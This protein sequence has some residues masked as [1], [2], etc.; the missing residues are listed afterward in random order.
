MSYQ[1]VDSD[2][3]VYMTHSIGGGLSLLLQEASLSAAHDASDRDPPPSCAPRTRE[4][5]IADIMNWI[6][7]SSPRMS[8]MWLNGPFGNGKSAIMQTIADRLRSDTSLEHH[9]AA[10]FFFGRGKLGRDKAKFLIPTIAYQITISIPST[11]QVIDKALIQDP[12]IILKKS[13]DA[14]LRYL[15]TR[16]LHEVTRHS[17]PSAPFHTPTVIIDGLDECEGHDFQ[18]L[19]LKAIS[20]AV[21]K[22]HVPL[23]FLI[24]SRPDAQ[25]SETFRIQPLAQHH[26]PITLVDDYS[27][28]EELRQFLRSGFDEICQRRFDIISTV[29]H[30]WPS[31][32]DVS[33]LAYRAS[34]QF[35][36]AETVLRFVDSDMAH[37]THQLALILQRQARNAFSNMDELYVQILESC[38]CQEILPSFLCSLLTKEI[39]SFKH[40]Y[41]LSAESTLA[42]L[43]AISGLHPNNISVIL[44]WLP[45]IVGVKWSSQHDLPDGWLL[46]QIMQLYSPKFII[47]HQSF[48]E[49]LTDQSRSSKFHVNL[50]AAYNKMKAHLDALLA[51]SLS[52]GYGWYLLKLQ[53][54]DQS[55]VI[56]RQGF[57][58]AHGTLFVRC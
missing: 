17:P 11:R 19:I 15:I 2:G 6:K 44:R 36:Y 23:R 18:R 57:T 52:K 3:P 48:V 42:D 45:A 1:E 56:N 28:R 31:E 47:H 38:P 13:I 14:Q 39:L 49:F 4:R 32:E 34:G 30:P 5:V 21:F 51:E 33:T 55:V 40:L 7:D 29:E 41:I 20:T 25:I 9:L 16:P 43:A 26:Y 10:S 37:P 12:T 8:V 50:N 22:E 24:A 35:L 54:F 27:T 46:H 53:F 58:E